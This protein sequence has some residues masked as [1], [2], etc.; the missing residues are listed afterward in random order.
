MTIVYK[1]NAN[2]ITNV[3][4]IFIDLD[5][6]IHG[7]LSAEITQ[8]LKDNNINHSLMLGKGHMKYPTHIWFENKDDATLFKLTWG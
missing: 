6:D 5:Y 4:Y 8:W 1:L 7:T 2:H 3:K